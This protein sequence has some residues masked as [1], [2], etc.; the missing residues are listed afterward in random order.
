MAKAAPVAFVLAVLILA[1]LAAADGHAKTDPA[2]DILHV[3]VEGSGQDPETSYEPVQEAAAHEDIDILSGRHE[4][5]G[6]DLVVTLRVAGDIRQ[7][8]SAQGGTD[9]LAG[10]AFVYQVSMD[11]R[12]DGT[13]DIRFT[14]DAGGGEAEIDGGDPVPV[15]ATRA[16]DTLQWMLEWTRAGAADKAVN[17]TAAAT[18]MHATLD[19]GGY[20]TD[21]YVDVLGPFPELRGA[22]DPRRTV[23]DLDFEFMPGPAVAIAA[24]AL[25]VAARSKR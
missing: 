4:T 18:E 6:G 9:G 3:V 8:G 17:W 20:R 10:K 2:G 24:A 11:L 7:E 15:N 25:L 21:T 23:E 13:E 5:L 16:G 1:P 12:G 22:Y 19:G 14:F